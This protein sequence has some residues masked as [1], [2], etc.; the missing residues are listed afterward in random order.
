M[1]QT[2]N[3]FLLQFVTSVVLTRSFRGRYYIDS[4]VE[5]LKTENLSVE[6]LFTQIREKLSVLKASSL[7]M[8]CSL[9]RS[10]LPFCLNP[11]EEWTQSQMTRFNAANY[12]GNLG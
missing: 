11:G 12:D 7:P 9:T 4:L 3:Q 10:G 6:D 5:H 2:L 8:E 1:L